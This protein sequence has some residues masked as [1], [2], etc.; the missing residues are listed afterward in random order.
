MTPLGGG[1]LPAWHTVS[2][3]PALLR[4]V[5]A[6]TSAASPLTVAAVDSLLKVVEARGAEAII[7][8]SGEVPAMRRAGAVTQLARRVALGDIT[9]REA[10]AIM[11]GEE[12]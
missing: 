8:T 9:I 12:E 11:R 10:I 4:R 6:G 7:I 3:L 5:A 2:P 1:C